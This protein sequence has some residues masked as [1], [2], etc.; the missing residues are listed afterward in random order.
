MMKFY[1]YEKAIIERKRLDEYIELIQNYS[2]EDF[3]SWVIKCYTLSGS[4]T[5]VIKSL[6][7]S[8]YSSHIPASQ[9]NREVIKAVIL[10]SPQDQLHSIVKK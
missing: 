9:N 7:N 10:S 8:P 6:G 5:G 4:I 1:T 2:V 3:N